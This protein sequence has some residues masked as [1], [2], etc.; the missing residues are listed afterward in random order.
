MRT[1][2]KK[3]GET[4]KELW[5]G[6]S[7]GE[8]PHRHRHP[9]TPGWMAEGSDADGIAEKVWLNV[10]TWGVF[11]WLMAGALHLTML[12]TVQDIYDSADNQLRGSANIKRTY[13]IALCMYMFVSLWF[14]M[15]FIVI[16]SYVWCIF[17]LILFGLLPP[18]YRD[19]CKLGLQLVNPSTI[20]HFLHLKHLPAHAAILATGILAPMIP[21]LF[22]LRKGD[23]LDP[24]LAITKTL[25]VMFVMPLVLILGYAIYALICTWRAFML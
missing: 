16:A 17:L 10:I 1:V 8:I 22:Y 19:V 2:R 13:L 18:F 3:V 12:K 15:L 5:V 4:A 24:Q 6:C 7:F 21:L 11:A 9:R 23:L 20:F 14:R 25:R